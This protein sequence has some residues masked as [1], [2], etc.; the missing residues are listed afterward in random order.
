MIWRSGGR[1]AGIGLECALKLFSTYA[2]V[3]YYNQDTENS[4]PAFSQWRLDFA[5]L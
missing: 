4:L 1:S 2:L 5:T 3:I